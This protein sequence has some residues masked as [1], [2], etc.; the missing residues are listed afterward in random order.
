M[1]LAENHTA[2]KNLRRL[3]RKGNIEDVMSIVSDMHTFPRLAW[4]DTRLDLVR[5]LTAPEILDL[6]DRLGLGL[7]SGLEARVLVRV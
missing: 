7:G 1:D 2:V 4:G 5:L 3:L 6:A